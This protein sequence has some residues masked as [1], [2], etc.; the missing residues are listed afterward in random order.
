LGTKGKQVFFRNVASIPF[1][2]FRSSRIMSC[3]GDSGG[4]V[5][6]RSNAARE[7]FHGEICSLYMNYLNSSSMK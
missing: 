5:I 3:S 7:C 1:W 6:E 2:L 4:E